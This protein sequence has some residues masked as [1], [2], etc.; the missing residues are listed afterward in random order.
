MMKPKNGHMQFRIRIVMQGLSQEV[1]LC[2]VYQV[3]LADSITGSPKMSFDCDTYKSIRQSS[4]SYTGRREQFVLFK[5]RKRLSVTNNL[6]QK[7]APLVWPSA[8]APRHDGYCQASSFDLE[9]NKTYAVRTKFE[10]WIRIKYKSFVV[11]SIKFISIT[12][13]PT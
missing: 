7:L 11:H 2:L 6:K 5:N 12:V 3:P 1:L 13:S 9:F 10:R 4:H 8:V